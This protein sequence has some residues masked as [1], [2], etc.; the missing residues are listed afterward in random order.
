MITDYKNKFIKYIFL[1]INYYKLYHF[2]P[3][4]K[5]TP[6]EKALSPPE[7]ALH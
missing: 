6:K 2:L 5:L 4:L 3:K 1:L 7:K